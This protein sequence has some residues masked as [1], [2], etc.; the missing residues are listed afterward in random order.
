MLISATYSTY[1]LF[2]QLLWENIYIRELIPAHLSEIFSGIIHSIS[3]L[4]VCIAL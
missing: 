1:F 2:F 4:E 3:L